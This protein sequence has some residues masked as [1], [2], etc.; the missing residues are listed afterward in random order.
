MLRN[1]GA[2]D[3]EI[4]KPESMGMGGGDNK[5]GKGNENPGG[6]PGGGQ[7]PGGDNLQLRRLSGDY[8]CGSCG[9]HFG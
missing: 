7:M 6:F 3:G 8:D 2:E 9:S 1:Y 4:Y 5:N